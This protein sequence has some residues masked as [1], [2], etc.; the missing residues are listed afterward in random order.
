MRKESKSVSA[1]RLCYHKL[2]TGTSNQLSRSRV[3][4]KLDSSKLR[5]PFL[6]LQSVLHKHFIQHPTDVTLFN[7]TSSL[8][9]P[10]IEPPK[11]S[12]DAVH[13]I[14]VSLQSEEA[15]IENLRSLLAPDELVRADRYKVE[16]ARRQFTICRASLRWLLASCIGSSPTEIAFEYGPHGK[17][18][19]QTGSGAT[20]RIEF[21][22]SHSADHA[23]IAISP[24]RHIGVDVEQIDETVRIIKLAERFFSKR[25]AAELNRLPSHD[26]LAG[27]FRGWTSKEAYLKAT[28]F[29][30]SFPLDR[31]S[32]SL[33]PHQPAKL[34]EVVDNPTELSRWRLLSLDPIPGFAAA[35]LFEATEQEEVALN[36][37]RLPPIQAT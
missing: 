30:L 22:V 16:R 21:S 31:F 5:A 4:P 19:L 37:W 25:E 2:V 14:Y 1:E 20:S 26:Q 12:A 15:R 32:V 13:V 33:N 8:W 36:R 23:L 17:P 18:A 6:L 35:I 9:H 34:C 3:S 7:M 24:N 11:L 27:F 29:G 28:G 10:L